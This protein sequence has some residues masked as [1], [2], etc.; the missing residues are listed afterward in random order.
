MSRAIT[1]ELQRLGFKPEQIAGATVRGKPLAD[2]EPE[3]KPNV[4]MNR[5]DLGDAFLQ[6]WKRLGP[7]IPAT[8]EFRFHPVRKWRFDLAWPEH[9]VAV[10]MEGGVW[11]M[12]GH[13]RGKIYR[14]NCEKYNEATILGWRV[15]RYVT[16][17]IRDN[18]LGIVK[19]VEGLLGIAVKPLQERS[20]DAR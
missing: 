4:P 15:L 18:P 8:R 12:G 7:P 5:R 20:H 1:N 19:E 16:N 9:K 2:V 3:T 13:T 10:E 14:K 6:V 11:T 17:D